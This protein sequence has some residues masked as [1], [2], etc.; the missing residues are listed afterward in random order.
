M[1]RFTLF[2]LSLLAVSAFAQQPKVSEK[3]DVNL[4]LI[5][6]T[7][8]DSR[9]HQILGLDKNDFVVTENGAPIKVDSVDYFTNRQLLDAPENKAAFKVDR[10]RDDRYFIFFFDKPESDQLFEQLN[11]ARRAVTH[12]IDGQMK[13]GDLVAI[14]GHDIRL[15]VYCDFTDNKKVIQ[16]ALDAAAT[17]ALGLDGPTG[18]PDQP[19]IMRNIDKNRMMTHTGTVYEALDTLASS[20]R[21]I[22]A[23]KELVLFTAGI[24]APDEE[25][26]G[27]MVLNESRYYRPMMEAL[28]DANVT[29]YPTNLTLDAPEVAHQTLTRM[30]EATGGQYFRLNVSFD[31]PLKRVENTTNGY[32][33]ISYY[34]PHA[35]GQHGFQKVNVALKNRE[36][37]VKSREGYAY[38]E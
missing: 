10:V 32:Y 30:A 25:V 36:F 27:P 7:V 11:R 37:T 2:A 26:R 14:A 20:L 28:N 34:S 4:V 9:G 18:T 22:R 8:T 19:S 15:R 1:R 13:P 38:G 12:F 5:D 16:S 21:P 33:L 35:P 3:V 17:H 24:V 31:T 23:R 6:A 29:V